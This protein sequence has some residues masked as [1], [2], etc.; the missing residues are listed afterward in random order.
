G[1]GPGAQYPRFQRAAAPARGG[2]RAGAEILKARAQ[3]PVAH[4]GTN[5]TLVDPGSSTRRN[6]FHCCRS[7]YTRGKFSPLMTPRV[8]P[9]VFH[10]ARNV[11]DAAQT[12]DVGAPHRPD[13]GR[14]CPPETADEG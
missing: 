2:D 11:V 3:V 8:L 13:R 4:A 9:W 5:R 12:R 6:R 1:V 14:S 10:Q 7:D